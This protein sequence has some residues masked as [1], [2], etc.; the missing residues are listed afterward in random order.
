MQ[1]QQ[2]RQFSTI[3]IVG[4]SSNK[5]PLIHLTIPFFH[6]LRGRVYGQESMNSHLFIEEL[7]L[8]AMP[9]F[10]L[11]FFFKQTIASS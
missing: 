1:E 3:I 2:L 9:S 4:G 6:K 11:S 10:G 5:L 8:K 7:F